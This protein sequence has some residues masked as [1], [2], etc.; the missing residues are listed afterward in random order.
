MVSDKIELHMLDIHNKTIE[1]NINKNRD[2][3]M[4]LEIVLNGIEK[5]YAWKALRAKEYNNKIF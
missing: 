4:C 1:I 5:R 2:P 3:H